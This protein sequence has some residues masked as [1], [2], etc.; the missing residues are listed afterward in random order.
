[1]RIL[2]DVFGSWKWWVNVESKDKLFLKL[3][4]LRTFWN[5]GRY[6]VLSGGIWNDVLEDGPAE[7]TLKAKTQNGAFWCYLNRCLGS[8]FITEIPLNKTIRYNVKLLASRFYY[9]HHSP[10]EHTCVF[11]NFK[12]ITYSINCISVLLCT[13][14]VYFVWV[15]VMGVTSLADFQSTSLFSK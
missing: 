15:V 7:K 9:L 13:Q 2:N 6:M 4:Q 10:F 1:M 5:Q 14:C 3:E 8:M 12:N 11:A